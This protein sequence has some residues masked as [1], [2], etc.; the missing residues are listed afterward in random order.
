MEGIVTITS[1]IVFVDLL[2]MCTHIKL[3]AC[4]YKKRVA[5]NFQRVFFSDILQNITSMK[6][7]SLKLNLLLARNG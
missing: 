4:T 7:K 2:H 1:Y 6:I 3:C 5:G